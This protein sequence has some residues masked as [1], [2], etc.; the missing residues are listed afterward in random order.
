[1]SKYSQ[2]ESILTKNMFDR[3]GTVRSHTLD[4]CLENVSL[5]GSRRFPY[6]WK[7]LPRAAPNSGWKLADYSMFQNIT[8]S[9]AKHWRLVK[10]AL[11]DKTASYP[12]NTTQEFLYPLS[13]GLVPDKVLFLFPT[14][15]D[16]HGV[17]IYHDFK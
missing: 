10:S 3:L 11:F 2:R 1:M 15:N 13:Q 16:L 9:L 12:S 14:D 17:K 5:N 4:E 7:F 6:D 8:P